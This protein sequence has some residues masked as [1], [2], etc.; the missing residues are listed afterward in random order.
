MP[1]ARVVY[2]GRQ[3]DIFVLELATPTPARQV[4]DWYSKNLMRLG[5][6]DIEVGA[7]P[8][9]NDTFRLTAR[10]ATSWLLGRVRTDGV[11][12]EVTLARG[13]GPVP[14][15]TSLFPDEAAGSQPTSRPAEAPASAPV[16]DGG[17]P[18]GVRPADVLETL[19][20]P[21]SVRRVGLPTEHGAIA[22]AGIS[23]DLSPQA[24]VIAVA[25]ALKE[26][27]WTVGAP[28]EG[29]APES[30]ELRATRGAVG[31]H[32]RLAPAGRGAAGLIVVGSSEA[33]DGPENP[34]GGRGAGA[35]KATPKDAKAAK[36]TPP[37]R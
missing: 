35:R 19:L 6:R 9:R 17:L 15:G 14:A 13:S 4:G 5:W 29:P 24:A 36:K 26:E 10:R 32:L 30:R 20:L 11:E 12:T 34:L 18:G 27:G 22:Q 31:L 21:D 37:G 1:G 33:V 2:G 7:Q 28:T 23:A 3:D 16:G 25:E 8:G